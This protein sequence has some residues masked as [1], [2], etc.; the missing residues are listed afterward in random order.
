[1]YIF[2]EARKDLPGWFYVYALPFIVIIA[3]LTLSPLVFNKVATIENGRI[4]GITNGPGIILFAG[5]VTVLI[6]GALVT[7][8]RKRMRA[9]GLVRKQL[10]DVLWGFLLTFFLLL[11]FNLFLPAFFNNSFCPSSHSL[12]F[13]FIVI[14]F[15]VSK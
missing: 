2:P 1:M 11:T 9:D 15:S 4:S 5:T 13:R 3:G 8:F 6:I 12:R 7:F 10:T 14:N